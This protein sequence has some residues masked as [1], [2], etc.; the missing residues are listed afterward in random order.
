MHLDPDRALFEG[1]ARSHAAV[2]ARLALLCAAL[3]ANAAARDWRALAALAIA[4]AL[5]GAAERMGAA[6]VRLIAIAAVWAAAAIT[7][8]VPLGVPIERGLPVGLRVLAGAAWVAWFG[9]AVSWPALRWALTRAGLPWRALDFADVSVA[10]GQILLRAIERQRAAAS[11]RAGGARLD[12]GTSAR[13]AAGVLDRALARG[14]RLEEARALRAPGEV[15]STRPGE[16]AAGQEGKDR[17]RGGAA[18]A[19]RGLAAAYRDGIPRLSGVDLHVERGAWVALAGP[20]GSGKSTLLRVAAGL[21]RPSAGELTR[22][23]R[24]VGAAAPSSERFDPRVALITQDPEDQLL[25][26]TPLDDVCW[27]LLRRG[28]PGAEACDRATRALEALG[29]LHLARRPVHALSFGEKKRVAFAAALACE[30]ELL[31]CDEPT[32][33]L[34]PVAAAR[35]CRA[36]AEAARARAIAV[37]WATHDL[38]QLPSAVER[39]VLLSGG[40]VVFDGPR[41]EALRPDRLEAAGLRE[42]GADEV[43]GAS[44]RGP[45]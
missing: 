21:L 32:A 7:L 14:E 27:G 17:P 45:E 19:A 31:L 40:A 15:K 23:G 12:L 24:R 41:G 29:V 20:S 1:E 4:G 16:A 26:S 2:L 5:C 39:V 44:G 18:I 8:A 9:G 25:G 10:H 33:G 35:L 43:E 6:R 37:V 13:L 42:R 3:T 30:P 28:V 22:L 11:V 36:L 34:D 38:G